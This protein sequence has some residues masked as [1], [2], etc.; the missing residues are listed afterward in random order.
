M[1]LGN[2]LSSLCG[3]QSGTSNLREAVLAYREALKELTR[4]SLRERSSCDTTL[5]GSP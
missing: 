5:G 3:L 1:G 2:V 4:D